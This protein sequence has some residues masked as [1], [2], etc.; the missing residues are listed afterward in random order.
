MPA[1]AQ[2]LLSEISN[3]RTP[4]LLYTAKAPLMN[5]TN[6]FVPAAPMV[7]GG[8]KPG[9]NASASVRFT[10]GKFVMMVWPRAARHVVR[11]AVM[12][13]TIAA[14]VVRILGMVRTGCHAANY[15]NNRKLPDLRQIATPG[16]LRSATNGSI[17]CR[18]RR[19]PVEHGFGVEIFPGLS[20][21]DAGRGAP[22]VG[23]DAV[24]ACPFPR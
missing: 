19:W 7:S 2:K 20:L 15:G 9:P 18:R 10:P 22:G 16:S 3:C 5:S 8:A 1:F 13:E 14:D 21:F 6:W 4:A 17:Y 23:E 24:R 12:S 11:R